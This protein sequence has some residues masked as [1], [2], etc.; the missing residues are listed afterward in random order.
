MPN[1]STSITG[2]LVSLAAED[3]LFESRVNNSRSRPAGKEQPAQATSL[4]FAG[5]NGAGYTAR[6]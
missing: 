3:R 4:M 1:A 2:D 5:T 6:A